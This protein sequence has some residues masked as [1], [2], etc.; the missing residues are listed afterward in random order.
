MR[1]S[2]RHGILIAAA[3]TVVAGGFALLR[4]FGLNSAGGITFAPYSTYRSDPLGMMALYNAVG[5]LDGLQ[6]ERYIGDFSELPLGKGATLFIAGAGLG[7]DPVPV[8]DTLEGF[9]ATG[10]RLVIAFFP[11][12]DD[13]TLDDLEDA[14]QERDRREAPDSP[15]TDEENLDDESEK[16][17]AADDKSSPD[18]QHSEAL[19][20]PDDEAEPDEEMMEF[21]PPVEDISERWT[22]DYEFEPPNGPIHLDR[23]NDAVPVAPT[24]EGRSGLYFVPPAEGW[25][26]VYGKKVLAEGAPW[27]GV[28]ERKV[29]AGTVVLC[30][31][32]YFLS[33]EALRANRNPELLAWLLGGNS[34]VL[35]SEAHLGTQQ[36]DRIMTLVRRYR[37][38]GVLFGFALLGVLFVWH[39]AASLIPRREASTRPQPASA[40]ERSQQDGLDNLLVRFISRRDL[41]ETCVREWRQHLPN[42][43][44]ANRVKQIVASQV[45]TKQGLEKEQ[46]LIDAYNEIARELHHK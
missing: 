32:A 31:D 18:D 16:N 30:S 27:C 12:G 6:V 26:P 41:L 36:R 7:P 20:E 3:F 10:G 37:L 13:G 19:P 39:N 40:A 28:M 35:F 45:A 9:V 24:L 22:F 42:D 8:L 17:A 44:K 5:R 14:L 4:I 46:D 38:H 21:G 43:P 23:L 34:S 1:F 2:R 15:P 33:N 25:T 11:L 29:G